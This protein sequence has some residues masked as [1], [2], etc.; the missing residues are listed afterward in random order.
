M[1]RTIKPATAPS[2]TQTSR[3]ATRATQ[4]DQGMPE[5]QAW[6]ARKAGDNDHTTQ[7]HGRSKPRTKTTSSA[8]SKEPCPDRCLPGD[9]SLDGYGTCTNT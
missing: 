8:Q 9:L 6:C 7:G 5:P 4:C 3:G 1:T 2:P